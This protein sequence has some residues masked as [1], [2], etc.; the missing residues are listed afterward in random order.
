MGGVSGG[1]E[2]GGEDKQE[3]VEVQSSAMTSDLVGEEEKMDETLSQEDEGE[4]PV[5]GEVPGDSGTDKTESSQDEVDKL[6]TEKPHQKPP[7]SYA[8]LIVQA[9]LASKERKQTL[10]N[11]YSFIAEKYPFY[12]LEDKGWKVGGMF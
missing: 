1:V 5:E 12:K 8:Q 4:V 3:M 6:P 9:L 7:Y 11:I 10:S 2:D